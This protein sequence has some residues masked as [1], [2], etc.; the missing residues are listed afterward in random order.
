MSYDPYARYGSRKKFGVAALVVAV[1]VCGGL[2]FLV[3]TFLGP[4][5]REAVANGG[6]EPKE[7]VKALHPLA[8][9]PGGPVGTATAVAA[10]AAALTV[11]PET[12]Q[13][14]LETL[15][16][17]VTT[18]D[19]LLLVEQ[20]GRT[21]EAGKVRAAA[22]MI[23]RKALS[24]DQV[25]RLH[26][27][28]GEARLRLNK[29]R[30]VTEIGELEFNKRGRWALNLEDEYGSR[31]YLDLLREQGKWGVQKVVLPSGGR[32]GEEPARAM[33]VDALG[34][35]D[36]FLHAALRQSFET[37]KSFVDMDVV[38][39]AKIA[40]LC[41][42]FEEGQYRLRQRKPLRAVRNRDNVAAFLANVENDDGSAAA[43]F[44]INLKRADEN[45][46]WRVTEINLDGLLADY[47]DR[48]AGGDVYY[49]PLIRNPKG[50]DTLILYFGFDEEILSPRTE[51]QLEIVALLLQTDTGKELTLS[52][53]TDAI[54][55]A[56]YN[57]SLSG[58]RAEAVRQFLV[59]S[60]VAPR[61]IKTLALGKTQPRR[62]NTTA[63]GEDSP[64]G[65]RANRRTEIYLDF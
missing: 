39:D 15:G 11:E 57:K 16:I 32:A 18:V 20:I 47:A 53:H 6:E 38:S 42:V 56:A 2:L 37:A 17:G 27:L 5:D 44:G 34:I 22:S 23:G 1:V 25:K 13:Q 60:G 62:P 29:E 12:T 3:S 8:Q 31:I 63:S 43:Q 45:S 48:V 46:P 40:G 65:R 35:T 21:L 61:Q 36:A 54:G 7:A 19:P 41:I 33:L 50:G 58:R 52:G 26:A 59:D 49:T 10:A 14:I 55:S 24:Q 28:A 64:E 9:P 30:P 51:R 4:G